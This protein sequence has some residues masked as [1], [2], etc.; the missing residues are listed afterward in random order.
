MGR[1]SKV[2][3][4]PSEVRDLVHR[5][6]RD[7]RTIAQ[8]VEQLQAIDADVSKSAVG[9]YTKSYKQLLPQLQHARELAERVTTQ[10]NENPRGDVG[11]LLAETLRL[12]AFNTIGDLSEK[13]EAGKVAKPGEIMFLAKAI[14][15]LES[16]AKQSIERR[17]RER[18]LVKEAAAESVKKEGGRLGLTE[19]AIERMTQAINL[20]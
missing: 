6:I 18:Q 5:L 19:E 15:D 10:V 7:G 16:T 14:K 20:L 3:T 2:D 1:R 11:T 8:I 4:L 13:S 17:Q 9:R 12:L